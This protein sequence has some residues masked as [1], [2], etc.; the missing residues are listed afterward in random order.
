[1]SMKSRHLRRLRGFTLM[2]ILVAIAVIVV[3]LVGVVAVFPVALRDVQQN[4]DISIS[5]EIVQS[6]KSALKA[7]FANAKYDSQ[8]GNYIVTFVHPG[9]PGRTVGSPLS[10]TVGSPLSRTVGPPRSRTVRLPTEPRCAPAACP[11]LP[12][13]TLPNLLRWFPRHHVDAALLESA[14]P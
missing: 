1:M 7:G 2:E 9:R 13:E 12:Q 6:V 8:T 3:G 5:A 10:R 14:S 4:Q 11:L